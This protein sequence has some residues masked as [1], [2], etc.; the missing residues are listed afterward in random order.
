MFAPVPIVVDPLL[1]SPQRAMNHD[2]DMAILQAMMQGIPS[3]ELPPSSSSFATAVVPSPSSIDEDAHEEEE[4]AHCRKRSENEYIHSDEDDTNASAKEEEEDDPENPFDQLMNRGNYL[5]QLRLLALAD[6]QE[7]LRQQQKQA[8]ASR[9]S[10]V[11][12]FCEE[13]KEDDDTLFQQEEEEEEEEAEEEEMQD[14]IRT[15]PS[16]KQKILHYNSYLAHQRYYDDLKHNDIAFMDFGTMVNAATNEEVGGGRLVVE[17]RKRL[18][19]GGVCWDAAFVLGEHVIANEDEW[20]A[21]SSKEEEGRR[22]PKVVELGA[23]TGLTGLMIGKATRSEVTITDLPELEGLMRD[24]VRRNFGP[25]DGIDNSNPEEDAYGLLPC[26]DA[27]RSSQPKGTVTSRILR[28]G[29]DA[30]YGPTPYDVILGADIVTSLYDPHALA[31]T[32]HALSG[33]DTKIYISGKTR[34]DKPHE[35][36]E[37]EMKQLFE[38][39]EKVERPESRLRSPNVFVIVAGGKK[40][41]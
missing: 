21:S 34:L 33:P 28:W 2:D 1:T 29:N 32:L 27:T 16:T 13:K 6:E 4:E 22:M 5:R 14:V 11:A 10:A 31:Q 39:V 26:N 3:L 12:N 40:S 24:N 15:L 9:Q 35:E 23:G 19:K 25:S 8:A 17:Q 36:F 41:L 37:G 7:R 20:N 38:S 30:D 18:G